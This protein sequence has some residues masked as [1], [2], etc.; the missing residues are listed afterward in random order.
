M[1]KRDNSGALFTNDK[2][3]K[4]TQPDMTGNITINGRK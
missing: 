4:E 3:T 2:K 1:E